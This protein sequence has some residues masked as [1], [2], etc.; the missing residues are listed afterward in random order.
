MA[1]SGRRREVIPN[2]H[3]WTVMN[4]QMSHKDKNQ[5]RITVG[6][7]NR[8]GYRRERNKLPIN[9]VTSILLTNGNVKKNRE[10]GRKD[11]P[12]ISNGQ[13]GSDRE[14]RENHK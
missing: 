3:W 9:T 5:K 2:I 12:P 4:L 8:A 13:K 10:R 14:S 1:R 6:Y 7:K 11:T